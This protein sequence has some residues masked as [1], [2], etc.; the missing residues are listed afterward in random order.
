M[1]APCIRTPS[2][3]STLLG[4]LLLVCQL[5]AVA[6]RIQAQSP[7]T[8]P[9]ALKRAHSF[10]LHGERFEDPYFWLREKTNRSVLRY[11]TAEN[12]HTEQVMQPTR[13]LQKTLFKEIKSHIKETDLSVPALDNGYY[14]Y[15]RSV[16]GKQYPIHCR[17][18]GD[19]Q[20]KEEI[21]LDLNQMARGETFMDL[22]DMSVSD[23]SRWLAFTT[24]VTGFREYTLQ[25]K[26]L[27][28][29]KLLPIRIPRVGDVEWAADN[30]TFFYTVEDSAKRSY[31][32]Y[33]KRLDAGSKA[34]L[35]YEEKDER[36]TLGVD[37][38]R[39][40]AFLVLE[41]E[42]HTTTEARVLPA[43]DPEGAWTLIAPRQPNHEY[44][45]DHH[46]DWFYIRSNREGRNFAL[47]RTP[48]TTPSPDHWS[49][50]LPH[51]KDVLLQQ[52]SFFKDFYVLSEVE[53]ALTQLRIVNLKSGASHRIAFPEQAF[54]AYV[55]S[56][57]SFET[58]LLR[59]GYESFT[60]P[61]SVFDYDWKKK[62]SVRLKQ[63]EVPGGFDASNYVTERIEATAADG[64]NVPISLVRRKDAP[65]DGSGPLLLTGYGAYGLASWPHFSAAR[66]ALL[67]RGAGFAI[68]HIRG[69]S[70]LG[71]EWHDQ[72]RM[73][74]KRN[75]FTDFI[76]CADRLVE[77]RYT[78]REKLAIQGGSAGGLLIAAALN[79]R[80]DLCGTA[81]LDVPFV[82]VINT[83]LDESLPLTVGEFEEWGN[84]K[85]AEEFRY[86]RSYCPYTNLKAAAYPAMLVNTSLNDS[87]V[88]YWEP[89]KYT[90]RLRGLKQDDRPLLLKV[91]MDAGHGGASGRYDHL[92]EIAFDYAFLLSRW[93]IRR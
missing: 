57:P 54:L 34:S 35:V 80:P 53:N 5:G 65:K 42:S 21:L 16:K 38:T 78:S 31:Q 83:M 7:T 23:D 11:L 49:V 43:G 52:M 46:G 37:R 79:L 13:A 45:L 56:N 66:L 71:K 26:D 28:N 70:D 76:A 18:K 64:R 10:T 17:R 36:F 8:P 73:L 3:P 75:S 77:A 25:I 1:V 6:A 88:M 74:N 89:A 55:H 85:N 47:L 59:Y 14:Y 19:M 20:A 9:V 27:T 61:S 72:G 63:T 87:Q 29:G 69:G 93:G 12:Q 51:R 30:R 58:P 15:S 91:N 68:A 82:D 81:I 39:S 86:L 90:A 24:D 2:G 50:V 92:K 32:L 60:T 33:R 22:G 48:V 44:Y 67:D 84:P 4:I 40:R 62:T 41:V